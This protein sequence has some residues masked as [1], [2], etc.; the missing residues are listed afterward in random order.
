MD[1]DPLIASG[2]ED[3]VKVLS[4]FLL[5][6]FIG[7]VLLVKKSFE[8]NVVTDSTLSFALL[9]GIGLTVLIF[10]TDLWSLG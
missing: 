3:L 10:F 7:V 9:C 6:A 4:M 5:I 2:W 8:G 1:Q